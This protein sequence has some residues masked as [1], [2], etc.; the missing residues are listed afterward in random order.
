MPKINRLFIPLLFISL[1]FICCNTSSNNLKLKNQELL[2]TIAILNVECNLN[3]EKKYSNITR[4][5]IEEEFSTYQEYKIID[6]INIDKILKELS[7]ENIGLIDN[8]VDRIGKMLKA[9]RLLLPKLQKVDNIWIL[10]GRLIDVETGSVIKTST[11]RVS[12][13]NKLDGAAKGLS[14]RITERLK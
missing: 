1:L 6:R 12:E 9:D 5:F 11:G 10:T 2:Y 7:L 3:E 13:P 14:R 4:D 8:D